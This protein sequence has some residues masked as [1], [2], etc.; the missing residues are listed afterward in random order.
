[1]KPR[2]VIL[3]D[4][5]GGE[6]P[7]WIKRYTD[8]LEPKFDIQYYDVLELA[9]IDASDFREINI[10][11]QFLNG[12]IDAAVENLLRLEKEKIAVLGF[13]IGGTIAWKAALKGLNVFH[14]VAVSSTRVRYETKF[15][16]CEIKLF[17]GENDRNKPKSQWFSDLKIPFQ[18]LKN[19]NHQLYLEKTQFS[20]ICAEF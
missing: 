4:L 20:L 2:L 9:N 10:H 14:L 15:P 13:S 5:F 17:F 19:Q 8:L 11:N 12:G 3:S 18:I 6:N 7:Q 1:M 16:N